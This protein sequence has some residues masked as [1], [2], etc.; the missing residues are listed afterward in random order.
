MIH[1]RLLLMPLGFLN[2]NVSLERLNTLSK[3]LMTILQFELVEFSG[4]NL[5]FQELVLHP[6]LFILLLQSNVLFLLHSDAAVYA[7]ALGVQ[8]VTFLHHRINISLQL[9]QTG[10]LD[11]DFLEFTV[12][13]V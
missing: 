11:V 12:A 10:Q 4:A 13:S 8:L 3:L 5:T 6:Q 2:F 9:S 7:T 1:L